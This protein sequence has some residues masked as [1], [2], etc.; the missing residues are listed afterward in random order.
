MKKGFLLFGVVLILLGCFCSSNAFAQTT[1]KRGG[2]IN[3]GTNMDL[4]SPDIHVTTTLITAALMS[5]VHETLVGFGEDME[6][7]P[8]LAERWE[9]SPDFKTYTFYLRK[10]KL[11]HNGREMVGDDVKF[12]LE[13]IMR[14]SPKKSQLEN[15]SQIEVLDKYTVRLHM[16]KT[17]ASLL[18]SLGN[19][20]PCMGIV[21]REVEKQGDAMTQPIGTGPF[22]F[23]EW[24]PDR[25]LLL[26]RF[27][28]YKPQPGPVNGFGGERI[29][30]VDKI[31]FVPIAEESVANMALLNKEI[32]F[33]W[34]VPFKD[35]ETY[36]KEYSKRGIILDSIPGGAFYFAYFGCRSPLTQNPKFRMACAYAID[37]NLIMQTAIRGYGVVNPSFVAA[38]SKLH[39]PPHDKW[40]KKDVNKA[41]QLLQEIGYKGEPLE[42]KTTKRYEGLYK[43]ALAITSELT[44]A[45]INA[46]INVMEW[47]NMVQAQ[48][49]GDLQMMTYALSPRPDPVQS[50]FYMKFNGF[51][52]Q[53]PR[54]GQILE[55]AEKT[56]DFEKRRKLFEEAH[57]LVYEGVPIIGFY[58]YNYHQ[59]YWNYV[60]GYKIW[61]TSVPRFWGVWLNK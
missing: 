46:Q 41:K 22:K 11:F 8:V 4:P 45:G 10:G 14:L 17:D 58:N 54:M 35:V 51:V 55:E 18:G 6:F 36:R 32:D 23:V 59:G 52:D 7:V 20:E 26:E 30:Y 2:I 12:S 61:G 24:K 25:Y 21:P 27:D 5:H 19:F 3:V 57:N 16:K 34:Y 39:T 50:Y 38:N 28:Q 31:K 37:Q 47:A 60:K 9:I 42:I 1:P 40:Y 43:A 48:Y 53:Y 13:R 29:P 56:M 44:A 49:K 33:L 15:I